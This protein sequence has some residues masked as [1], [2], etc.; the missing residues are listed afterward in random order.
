MQSRLTLIGMF[1]YD[2]TLF[3]NLSMPAG[4][5]T[6]IVRNE[7]LTKSGE[8]EVLY[9][10][11]NFVKQMIDHWSKKHFRTFQKWIDVLNI[12]YDPLNNYDRKEEYT[13]VRNGSGNRSNTT[14]R[15]SIDNSIDNEN[16][17][18]NSAGSSSGNTTGSTSPAQTTNTKTTS[19][20]A[21]DAGTLQTKEQTIDALSLQ[22]AGSDSSTTASNTVNTD[23]ESSN[24]ASSHTA[25]DN[26][27]ENENT[28]NN[29]V[30]K[31]SA[32]LF[33]NIGVTTSQQMLQSEL[34][35]ARFNLYEQIADIFVEEFCLMVY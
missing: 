13:D 19:V 22:V 29:E 5:D 24:R 32:H 6:D 11:P 27:T 35:I 20:S 31:H 2:P 25:S 10:D 3:A 18:S 7:I 34:D 26:M 28:N 14:G 30:I 17:K 12:E 23:S 33:G 4:I 16:R 21:F 1:E 8:F 9:S 15:N